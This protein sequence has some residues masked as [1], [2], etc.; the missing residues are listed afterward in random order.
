PAATTGVRTARSAAARSSVRNCASS[1]ANSFA[2]LAAS[3]RSAVDESGIAGKR[4]PSWLTITPLPN[5]VSTSGFA[6]TADSPAASTSS[7]SVRVLP[8][9]MGP[10]MSVKDIDSSVPLYVGTSGWSYPSWRPGFYPAGLDPREFLSFYAQRFRTVEL[11]TTGY[12]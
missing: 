9:N 7:I 11:N 8:A 12:R 6:A 3:W 2:P 1:T 4:A 5:R 10:Q